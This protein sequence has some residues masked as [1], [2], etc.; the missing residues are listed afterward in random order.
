MTWLDMSSADN[1][2]TRDSRVASHRSAVLRASRPL[3]PKNT[4]GTGPGGVAIEPWAQVPVPRS[5][6]RTI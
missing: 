5:A 1:Y 6:I 2:E 4:E 3:Q